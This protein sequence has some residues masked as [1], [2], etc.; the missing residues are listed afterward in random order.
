MIKKLFL[1]AFLFVFLFL[2]SGCTLVKGVTGAAQGVAEGA[3]EDYQAIKK[4]DG[5]VKD[6]LW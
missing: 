6:N 2:V 3:K 5:W 4:A 1:L